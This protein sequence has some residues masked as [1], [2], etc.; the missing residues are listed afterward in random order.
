VRDGSKGGGLKEFVKSEGAPVPVG[1]YSQA[2]RVAPFLFAAGQVGLDPRTGSLV[3][4]GIQAQTRRALQNLTA[5]VE[6][7]GGSLGDVVKTTVFLTTMDHFKSMN[8]VYAEFFPGS[9]PARSTV[10]VSGLPLGALVEI[11]VV[12]CWP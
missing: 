6:S 10:A 1:P 2:V 12:A 11:E 5:V 9:P 4:G 8:E 3:D 7:A